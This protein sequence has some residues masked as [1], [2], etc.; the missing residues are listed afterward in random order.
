MYCYWLFPGKSNFTKLCKQIDNS[1][2]VDSIQHTVV[3][4]LPCF[5]IT[6]YANRHLRSYGI[7]RR[8]FHSKSFS[9][10][11]SQNSMHED[12]LWGPKIPLKCSQLNW[13]Y[14]HQMRVG[15]LRATYYF[16]LRIFLSRSLALFRCRATFEIKSLN[17]MFSMCRPVNPISYD[18]RSH[19]IINF[20]FRWAIVK[21]GYFCN[22]G[23]TF[24]HCRCCCSDRHFSGMPCHLENRQHH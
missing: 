20:N 1:W 18:V 10:A 22:R 2:Y 15:W 4:F 14:L 19:S 21:H 23:L 6:S 12:H 24:F 7:I 16:A 3:S 9:N 17:R 13:K 11:R 8:T 5:A